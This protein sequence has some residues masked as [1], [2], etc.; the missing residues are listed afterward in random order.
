MKNCIVGQSGGP[1]AVINASL[2]G[3]ASAALKNE[4]IGTVYGAVNGIMGVLGENFI[5][6]ADILKTK[7]DEELLKT[8]PASFLG[9]CRYKL[10]KLDDDKDDF[11]KIFDV[12]T[13][14]N[15]GY[16]FYIGG[17]DSMDTVDKLSRYAEKIGYDI[18]I[19]GVPKTI[20]NDLM[21]T[22]HTPGF[23]SAAKYIATTVREVGLDSDV[24]DLNSVTIVEIMGRNAGWLTAA[25]VL[26]RN[27]KCAAPHLIYLPESD[28][29]DEKFF[30]DIKELNAKGVKNIIVAVS[31]GIR[32]ADGTYVCDKASSGLVD[33]FGHKCLSGTAKVLENMVRDNLGFKARGIEINVLQRCA[34]HFTS[35]VDINEA[36][37]VGAA[38]VAEAVAGGTGK[39][40]AYERVSNKPYKMQI[41]SRDIKNIANG[42]RIVPQ[43]W[44]S[45]GNDVTQEMIDYVQPLIEGTP[46]LKYENGLPV[47]LKR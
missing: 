45:N 28:F 35:L 5:D 22:D 19:I 14:Y 18:N 21:E 43:E 44:I 6:M 10:P 47:Y 9:S 36:F 29:D 11:K 33:T 41:V 15:I 25:S 32:Y 27:E 12:F 46:T 16:F 3:V 40:M 17:N 37:E 42:E 20:D 8:T 31:E 7:E 34:S 4:N 1:T 38:G 26:A 2:C 30:N 13:K 23:G 24:Y 39:M